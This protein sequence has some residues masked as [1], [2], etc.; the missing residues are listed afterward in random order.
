MVRDDMRPFNV[1]EASPCESARV[2]VR[3]CAC[4]PDARSQALRR[5]YPAGSAPRARAAGAWRSGAS[6]T[7]GLGA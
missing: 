2:A 5:L 1:P 4:L 7:V 6:A 3:V